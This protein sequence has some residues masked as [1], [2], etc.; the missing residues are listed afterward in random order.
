MYSNSLVQL[1]VNK[2]RRLLCDRNVLLFS[3]FMHWGMQQ[4]QQTWKNICLSLPRKLWQTSWRNKNVLR[5]CD[6]IIFLRTSSSQ[7]KSWLNKCKT[8]WFLVTQNLFHYFRQFFI[9]VFSKLFLN[10]CACDLYVYTFRIEGN[11]AREIAPP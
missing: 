1:E 4:V 5:E 11:L 6:K 3:C 10:S 7:A 2:K 9:V 8:R